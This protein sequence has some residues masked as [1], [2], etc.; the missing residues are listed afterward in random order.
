MRND[1]MKQVKECA[2]IPCEY[3]IQ[4][5]HYNFYS[6]KYNDP[7]VID[8][9]VKMLVLMNRKFYTKNIVTFFAWRQDIPWNLRHLGMVGFAIRDGWKYEAP[10]AIIK[11]G[12]WRNIFGVTWDKFDD[13][14]DQE[15][16]RIR[17]FAER[18]NK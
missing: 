10:Y 3:K 6:G 7:N 18:F 9:P 13:M 16:Q 1:W 4:I 14:M 8:M 2:K 5:K 17:N 12:K 11:D 15:D